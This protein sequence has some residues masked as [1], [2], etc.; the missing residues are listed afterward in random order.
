IVKVRRDDS[1]G[2][3][4]KIDHSLRVQIPRNSRF[5]L[6]HPDPARLPRD[7]EKIVYW[8]GIPAHWDRIDAERSEHRLLA[9]QSPLE[10]NYL[11][12]ESVEAVHV[13]VLPKL[14]LRSFRRR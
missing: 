7:I 12:C 5:A 10:R 3:H 2:L 13:D 9:D 6:D 11:T 14:A 1:I 8:Y 4:V